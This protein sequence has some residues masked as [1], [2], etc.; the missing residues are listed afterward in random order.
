MNSTHQHKAFLCGH[1]AMSA[2]P[3][4][5]E[6]NNL[7]WEMFHLPDDTREIVKRYFYP[8]FVDFCYSREK[9][10]NCTRFIK[11]INEDLTIP[12]KGKDIKFAVKEITLY[13]MPYNMALFSIHIE[14]ETDDLDDCTAL[15]YN[16]RS[17][18]DYKEIHQPFL[19]K[20][21][22]P[23]MEVYKLLTGTSSDNYSLLVENGNKLRIFQII[24]SHDKSL[25]NLS[26]DE[27]DKLLYE[28]ASVSKV[29][30][31]G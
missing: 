16:L 29:T 23:M 1:F 13:V 14:Q 18:Y 2:T 17:I 10:Q 26:E 28:L 6:L 12:I 7:G 4:S 24:N 20:A 21:I 15:L 27:K 19:D 3:S 11:Q 31:P 9:D 25:L 30:K 5:E 22:L 8:E